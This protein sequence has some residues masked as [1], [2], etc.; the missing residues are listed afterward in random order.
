[1]NTPLPN[2][3]IATVTVCSATVGGLETPYSVLAAGIL[4]PGV[5]LTNDDAYNMAESVAQSKYTPDAAMTAAARTWLSDGGNLTLAVKTNSSL[6][7][8]VDFG[9]PVHGYPTVTLADVTSG[10]WMGA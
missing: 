4:T 2:S 9:K 1:M 7:I 3:A 10:V 8:T 6:Y 5:V